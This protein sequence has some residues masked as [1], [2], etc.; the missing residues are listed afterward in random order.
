MSFPDNLKL[1]KIHSLY[2]WVEYVA[3]GKRPKGFKGA[4][5]YADNLRLAKSNAPKPA[6]LIEAFQILPADYGWS[7]L[8]KKITPVPERK[9]PRTTGPVKQLGPVI[10]PSLGYG[11]RAYMFGGPFGTGGDY[12]TKVYRNIAAYDNKRILLIVDPGRIFATYDGG[13]TWKGIDGSTGPTLVKTWSNHAG[14]GGDGLSGDA[15]III[16]STR[17]MKTSKQDGT[18]SLAGFSKASCHG[19]GNLNIMSLRLLR[20]RGDKWA[21]GSEVMLDHH[22]RHCPGNPGA[23]VLRLESGRVWSF[24]HSDTNIQG[25]IHINGK[26]SDDQG[27]NWKFPSRYP[28]I[29]GTKKMYVNYF[30][31]FPYKDRVAV[32]WNQRDNNLP[33]MWSYFDGKEFSSPQSVAG[34]ASVQS[35][36]ALQNGTVYAA[37]KPIRGK[38]LKLYIRIFDGKEW[39][40]GT[41]LDDASSGSIRSVSMTRSKDK[42]FCFWIRLE[43]KDEKNIWAVLYSYRNTDGVWSKPITISRQTEGIHRIVTPDISPNDYIPVFWDSSVSTK[44]RKPE[45]YKDLWVRFARVPSDKPWEEK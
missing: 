32:I 5:V 14:V 22:V 31:A 13:E 26:Y 28:S 12:G 16:R 19:G 35:A 45:W 42:L 20:F 2:A 25:G 18:I 1:E 21:L 27:I 33:V 9:F 24:W 10:L 39:K 17:N 7:E 40:T 23:V 37:M 30:Y 4:T 44:N 3:S 6:G 34:K 36:A 38:N 11:R 15:Y 29:Q 41:V 8:A 43:K